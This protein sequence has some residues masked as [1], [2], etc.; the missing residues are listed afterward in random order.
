MIRHTNSF[1]FSIII[2]ALFI[3]SLFLLYKYISPSFSSKKEEQVCVNLSC[4]VECV[5]KEKTLQQKP[6]PIEKKVIK[7][8][9][10]KKIEKKTELRRKKI[11]VKKA[12]KKVEKKIIEE[13]VEE[14]KIVEN[15]T[16]ISTL[17]K[18]VTKSYVVVTPTEREVIIKETQL[19][20]A[21]KKYV[22]DNLAK[23]ARLLQEN[24]YYPRRARK[25]G[26]QGEVLVKFN[27]S[28]NAEVTNV[29]V[30]SSP[31][32]ILSRGAIRTI[33]DLSFKFPKPKENL[34]LSVP[35]IYKL[36]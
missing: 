22:D 28:Q 27:L 26:V 18:K 32:D 13:V 7:K 21:Q 6:K 4:V 8:S 36:N 2:H 35:I 19:V 15:P 16:P 17:P 23:I 14:E 11:Y 33:N 29:Q 25:R 10:P 9:K 30:L 5:H 20:T 3:I 24:L 34:T 31:S 1:I 12:P